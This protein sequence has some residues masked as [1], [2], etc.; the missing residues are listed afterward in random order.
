MALNISEIAQMLKVMF[1][2]EYRT[3]GSKIDEYI[4]AGNDLL[5]QVK[6]GKSSDDKTKAVSDE[7]N[8]LK[9]ENVRAGRESGEKEKARIEQQ[10]ATKVDNSKQG[11][12]QKETNTNP[13]DKPI[14]AADMERIMKEARTASKYDDKGQIVVYNN[15]DNAT[16]GSYLMV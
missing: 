1:A 15:I 11:S 16:Q 4:K 12:Q 5:K 2:E 14:S 3:Y 7:I 13:N 6:E 9:S 8:R 10:N